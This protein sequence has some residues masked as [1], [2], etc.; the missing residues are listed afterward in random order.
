MPTKSL[1]KAVTFA[2]PLLTHGAGS[3]VDTRTYVHMHVHTDRHMCVQVKHPNKLKINVLRAV[4]KFR[5]FGI[6]CFQGR[7]QQHSSLQGIRLQMRLKWT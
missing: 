6:A 7:F 1:K 3:P 2:N 5:M 4:Q